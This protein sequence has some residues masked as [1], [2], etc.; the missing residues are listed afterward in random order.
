MDGRSRLPSVQWID[1]ASG[2]LLERTPPN[3]RVF[4]DGWGD[5]DVLDW[6]ASI[7]REPPDPSLHLVTGESRVID[8]LTE[9]DLTFDSPALHLP[10]AS[11]LGRARM[12]AADPPPNRV[13]LLMAAWNEHGYGARSKLARLLAAE[14]IATVMLENP[15]YGDRR[16]DPTDDR[17]IATVS[18]FAV[19]GRA[20]VVEGM[21]LLAHFHDQG[22]DTGVGGFSM[23]GNIAAF[24]AA[25]TGFPTAIALAAAS[26]SP[27]PPFLHGVMRGSLAWD[28]LGGDNIDTEQRLRDFFA[29]ATVLDHE[30]PPHV[31]AAE[32]L[33][34]T[35]DGFVPTSAV[36]ALHRHWP[37]SH[38]EWTRAGH[39]T[40]LWRRKDLMAKSA[41][42]AFQRLDTW[43]RSE[44]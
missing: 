17:P 40:L 26:H 19:M 32:L 14:G 7:V 22:Y 34:G 12:I 35:I 39:A 28:A 2:A 16:A 42:T 3:R 33:A 10:E 29:S 38:I 24:V 11:R 43:S 30:P 20:A 44:V 6:Y 36:L 31:A 1:R 21:A 5:A 13:L 9:T 27:A 8:G 23:G 37:G 18:D 25:L 4:R 15:F 41:V